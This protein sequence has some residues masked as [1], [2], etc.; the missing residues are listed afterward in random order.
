MTQPST[1]AG[2]ALRRLQTTFQKYAVNAPLRAGLRRG[3]APGNF[4]LLETVGRRTGRPH[5]TPVGNGLVGDTFWVVA[6]HGER[7]DWVRNVLA[8]PRVRVLISRRW[9]EGTATVVADDDPWARRRDLD[10]MHGLGG[11]LDGAVFRAA[12]STP[13]TVRIDLDP[14]GG[15][16]VDND[17]TRTTSEG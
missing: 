15:S 13:L 9:R 14:A 3:L 6:E 10:G 1:G 16:G 7:S 11:R 5:A 12:A 2:R 17:P 4:A 8:R